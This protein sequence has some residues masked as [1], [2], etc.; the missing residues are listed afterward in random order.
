MDNMEE[1][2]NVITLNDEDGNDMHPAQMAIEACQL[3]NGDVGIEKIK[4]VDIEDLL[5]RDATSEEQ[6]VPNDN[7]TFDG[8]TFDY[9]FEAPAPS[10]AAEGTTADAV[11]S[12]KVIIGSTRYIIAGDTIRVK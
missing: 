3:A 10:T 7:I 1:L 9:T 2:D 6:W 11:M 8:V 4:E 12:Q 5:G